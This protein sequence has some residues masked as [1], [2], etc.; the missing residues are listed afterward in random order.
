MQNKVSKYLEAHGFIEGRLITF[1]K[2][3]YRKAHPK[4][5]VLFNACLF[6]TK[7]EEVWWADVDLTRD[8]KVFYE[9]ARTLNETLILTPETPY[10]FIGLKE[11][12]KDMQITGK[13]AIVSQGNGTFVFDAPNINIVK[14]KNSIKK[15]KYG[16]WVFPCCDKDDKQLK[17]DVLA[18]L[19]E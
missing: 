7:G 3:L 14:N 13:I 19:H 9:T 1:S 2:S 17:K 11:T 16:I 5:I 8:W 12:L 4:H 15:R 18:L 6:N 10:R